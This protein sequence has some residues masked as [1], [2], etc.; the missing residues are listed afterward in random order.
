MLIMEPKYSF[1]STG[2]SVML[3]APPPEQKSC[4]RRDASMMSAWVT[5]A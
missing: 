2:M 5:R 4:G 1:S 3:M